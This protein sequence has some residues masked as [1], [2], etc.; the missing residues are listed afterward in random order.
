[1]EELE[2][3]SRNQQTTR[4]KRFAAADTIIT[5]SMITGMKIT[6]TADTTII[7]MSMMMT[8]TKSTAAVNIT[9]ITTMTMAAAPN[10]IIITSTPNTTTVRHRNPPVWST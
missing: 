6:A 8:N 4:T 9:I 3:P 7:T 2:N 5:M 10:T 1:M